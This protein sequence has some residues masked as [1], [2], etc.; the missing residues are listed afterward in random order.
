M[1]ECRIDLKASNFF[2]TKSLKSIRIMKF[3]PR[4]AIFLTFT[5]FT[6]VT[7]AIEKPN[8][9][10]F[11]VDDLGWQ[12]LEKVNDVGAPCPYKT[13]NII[14]LAS[15][16]M[17]LP[18]GYSPAPS[19]APSRAAILSGLHP[20]MTAYTHVTAATI[21]LKGDKNEFQEPFLGDYYD[22][23][24]P[25]LS[26]VLKKN[27]YTTGHYGKWHIGLNATAYGFEHVN[28]TRGIHSKTDDRTKDF[29]SVGDAKY[30][31]SK[32]KYPPISADFPEG[33][34]Y[35]KDD[36][37]DAALAFVKEHK[38][39]PFFLNFCHWMVHWPV[40]TRNGELLEYYCK[41][42]G[43][44]FP[45]KP[46]DM[47]LEGQQNPYFAAMV[48]TVDWSLGRLMDVLEQTDDPRHPGK[49]LIE[50]TYI[51]FTSDNGGAEKRGKE[52]ISDNYP[53]KKG[54]KYT[55]EGGV[56]VP[57]M[58]AGPGIEP[59][60]ESLELINQL[61]FFP[62]ILKLTDS[63]FDADKRAQLS[64]LDVSPVLLGNAKE[65]V[66]EEGVKR[67]SLFWHFPHNKM[68]AAIRKNDFKLYRN[69]T[70]ND[71][72]L[73]R[74][75]KD[76]KREDLEENN[77]LI[78]DPQYKAVKDTMIAELNTNLSK[79]NAVMPYLN[80]EFKRAKLPVGK[81][82]SSEFT[83]PTEATLHLAKDSP[84]AVEAFALFYKDGSEGEKAK[85]NGN[86]GKG[87]PKISYQVKIP[88]QLSEDGLQVK[89]KV[90]EAVHGVQFF[91]VDENNYGHYSEQIT[92]K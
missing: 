24:H 14:K 73:F 86:Y 16:G 54:K 56:R 43:Q 1:K 77:D 6:G 8:I 63:E 92:R 40:L 15:K 32:K 45:P 17:N 51:F 91:V 58:V 76:G 31:L 61:D 20:A 19:C 5:C 38:E 90:P 12:D 27:G 72:N 21:P 65:V 74:L 84:K 70:S 49:K 33:I 64:G 66:N 2:I 55:D 9:I 34:S 41:Q 13:P 53:L 28:Q 87:D 79:N 75:Y 11:Y 4:I 3:I 80:P 88:A 71:Y 37:T 60:S 22:L 82:A 10:I 89:V 36:L 35:P 68:R 50:T 30:P 81:L 69:Y 44:P 78:A 26:D 25:M 57:L 29:A 85:K 18:H 39:E 46:G 47:T 67:E 52:I 23:S 59:G 48:T 42:M 62:S 83:S 7:T